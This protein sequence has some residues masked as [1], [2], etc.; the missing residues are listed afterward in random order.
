MREEQE[1]QPACRAYEGRLESVLEGRSDAADD[2]V[3]TAHLEECARLPQRARS[4]AR[5]NR[6]GARDAS[7]RARS[8][9]LVCDAR[10][11]EHPRGTAEARGHA[12]LGTDRTAG[13]ATGDRRRR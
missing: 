1:I 13:L 3:F 9:E 10:D 5:S 7:P 11:G 4:R 6:V 8:R 12:G 2:A